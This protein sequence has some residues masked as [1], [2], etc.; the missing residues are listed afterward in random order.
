MHPQGTEARGYKLAASST[1]GYGKGRV[2][3]N[4]GRRYPADP[5]TAA[6]TVALM[7]ACPDTPHGRRLR[8]LIALLWR[9]GLRIHEALVLIESDLNPKT[10]AIVVRRG[11]GGKRRIVGMD[12]WGWQQVAPWLEERVRYPVGPVFCVLTGPTAGRAW[13]DSQVRVELKRLARRAGLRKRI[14][15]H[16]LRHALAVDLVREGTPVHLLQRQ[17]GHSNLSVTT[18]YLSGVTNDE[19]LEVAHQR[20]PP[21]LAVPDLMEV[22]SRGR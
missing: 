15:P 18:T 17:L 8:A 13:S 6:E 12:P 3:R 5:P 22:M 21:T 9:S 14:A 7:Q 19:V 16:Q 4:R 11:K 1:P 10:G 2:P 20:R